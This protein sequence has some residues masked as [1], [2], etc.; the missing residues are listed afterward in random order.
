[1][2]PYYGTA[3]LIELRCKKEGK[4]RERKGTRRKGD[5][6]KYAKKTEKPSFALTNPDNC[7]AALY[8][9]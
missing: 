6:F 9:V 8:Y 1:M 5:P 2:S 4:G 7:Y 3:Y